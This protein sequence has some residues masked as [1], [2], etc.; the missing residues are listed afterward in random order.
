MRTN[1]LNT[2]YAFLERLIEPYI[3]AKGHDFSAI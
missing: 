2:Q 3:G 1:T